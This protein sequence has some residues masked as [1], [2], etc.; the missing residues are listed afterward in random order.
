MSLN[1]IIVSPGSEDWKTFYAK[2]LALSS[3]LTLQNLQTNYVSSPL[4]LN[5]YEEYD[6]VSLWGGGLINNIVGTVICRI[7]RIG[8]VVTIRLPQFSSTGTGV[9]GTM[10]MITQLPPRFRP[11]SPEAFFPCAWLTINGAN[12]GQSTN[13]MVRIDSLGNISFVNAFNTNFTGNA[14]L[15]GNPVRQLITYVLA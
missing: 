1:D 12:V 11:N 14:G 10:S 3:G 15:N 9:A 5:Y 8:N 2:S 7:T 4:T 6:H 13:I